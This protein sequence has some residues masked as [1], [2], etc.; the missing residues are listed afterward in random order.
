MATAEDVL[1]AARGEIGYSRHA[2]PEKGT[3]YGRWYAG[4]TGEPYYG[5]SGVPYCAMFASWVFAQAGASCPG[6]PSAYCPY[7]VR[8][9][10]AAGATPYNEDARPGDLVLFDWGGDGVADHVGIVEANHPSERYLTT[11]EGNTSSGSAGSQG[12]GGGVYRR[13]RS[14][15]VVRCIV[16]PSYDAA[17][18]DATAKPAPIACDGWWGEDTTRLAQEVY[19]TPC[20]GIVSGQWAGDSWRHAGCTGGWVHDRTGAGSQL[21]AAIQ[22]DCGVAADGLFGPDSINAFIRNYAPRSGATVY[23]G[24]LDG[25]SITI[26]AFQADM[27][28]RAGR[29]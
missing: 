7:I 21:I 24:K 3:K 14:Y 6:L 27:N 8:D 17:G 10:Y 23:D 16:R 26:K 4:L 20:D 9:A 19:G 5:E 1:R 28:E 25:P 13:N 2:D 15:S 22:R 29:C 12:N 18:E 11:I